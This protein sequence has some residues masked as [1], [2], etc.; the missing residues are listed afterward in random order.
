S[1]MFGLLALPGFR[2]RFARV[3]HRPES[4]RFFAG[5]G[6]VSCNKPTDAFVAACRAGYDETAG[7]KRSRCAVV[8]LMPVCHFGFPQKLAVVAVHRDHVGVVGQHEQPVAGYR[9]TA[10]EADGGIAGEARRSRPAEMP[11]LTAGA[12][13]ERI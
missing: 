13:I 12:G 7:D 6:I 9:D 4:P 1:P 11:D 10:I 3:R 8:I 2:A 5:H